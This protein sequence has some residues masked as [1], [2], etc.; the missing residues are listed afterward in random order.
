MKSPAFTDYVKMPVHSDGMIYLWDADN[1]MVADVHVDD[2][3][4]LLSACAAALNYA[5]DDLPEEA[6]RASLKASMITLPVRAAG[7]HGLEITDA[8]GAV[9]LRIRGWGRLQYL[10]QD[11]AVEAQRLIAQAFC[12]AL[13]ALKP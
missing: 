11:V 3:Q 12:D 13:N 9:I 2:G 4:L 8:V 7:E 5:H 10:G 6:A 1:N